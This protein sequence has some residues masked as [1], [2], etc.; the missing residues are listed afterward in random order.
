MR[1]KV[2]RLF[3]CCSLHRTSS[4][5]VAREVGAQPVEALE[6]TLTRVRA[7]PLHEPLAA[8]DE[9]RLALEAEDLDDLRRRQ[10]LRQVLLVAQ[11][12]ERRARERRVAQ[13]AVQLA[14]RGAHALAIVGVDDVDDRVGAVVVVLPQLAE[15]LLATDVPHMELDILVLDGV[16]VEADR[17]DGLLHLV[18]LELLQD[19]RLAGGVEADHEDGGVLLREE[20]VKPRQDVSHDSKNTH[21][22]HTL[23]TIARSNVSRRMGEGALTHTHTLRRRG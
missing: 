11:H 9:V 18:Q 13:Q 6:E 22:S 21:S 17:R 20:A 19:G 23:D 10:A 16:D 14:L 12:E 2:H 1:A 7:A 4:L 15:L 3:R 8:A 5:R